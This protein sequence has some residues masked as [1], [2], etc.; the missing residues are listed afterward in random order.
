MINA[1]CSGNLDL[2][3]SDNQE[4]GEPPR[5]LMGNSH[6]GHNL[7]CCKAAALHSLLVKAIVASLGCSNFPISASFDTLEP[8]ARC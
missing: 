6:T 1:A 4:D 3:L 2:I 8:V 5:V 7:W